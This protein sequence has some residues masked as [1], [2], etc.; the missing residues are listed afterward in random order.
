MGTQSKTGCRHTDG[1]EMGR[2]RPWRRFRVT[3]IARR[4]SLLFANVLLCLSTESY[5]DATPTLSVAHATVLFVTRTKAQF[6]PHAPWTTGT[7]LRTFFSGWPLRQS[8][9]QRFDMGMGSRG[10][11]RDRDCGSDRRVQAGEW[12]GHRQVRRTTDRDLLRQRDGRA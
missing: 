8:W 12:M 5:V 9:C 2:P 10:W 1:W 7:C 6:R 11:G 4:W 3:P